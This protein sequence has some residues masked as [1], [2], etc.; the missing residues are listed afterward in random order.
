MEDIKQKFT[1]DISDL[2]AKAKVIEGHYQSF[3]DDEIALQKASQE[4]QKQ[5]ENEKDLIQDLINLRARSSDP[6]KIEEYTKNI[7][8]A[9]KRMR[10]LADATGELTAAEKKAKEEA[11][12]FAKAQEQAAKKTE[13]LGKVGQKVFGVLDRLTFGLAS[14]MKELF[15]S[16]KV[17]T[18]GMNILKA[19]IIST[20]IG[21]L[22]VAVASLAAYMTQTKE[23]A[24]LLDRGMTALKTSFKVLTDRAAD[25]GEK[26][27]NAFTNPK[28]AL[29]DIGDS[30]K[31]FIRDRIE[32]LLKAVDGVGNAFSS[33]MSGNFKDAA[34]QAGQAFID[35]NRSLNPIAIQ[36][37]AIYDFWKGVVDETTAEVGVMDRLKK[38][39][40]ENRDAQRE[41]DILR[42][43]S[44]ADIKALN[45]IAED[46]TKSESERIDAASKAIKLEQDLMSQ[47]LIL[48]QQRLDI[49]NEANKQS[50]NGLEDYEAAAEAEIELNNI[51][52]E[53]LELQTTLN[54]KLNIIRQQ[55][56][57]KRT[58]QEQ[59]Q[60][61]FFRKLVNANQEAE[62]AETETTIEENDKRLQVY[63]D[64]QDKRQE[65]AAETAAK[66]SILQQQ[67]ADQ[68]KQDAE[69]AAAL[70]KQYDQNAQDQAI[71][72]AGQI[73]SI[74]AQHSQDRI[75]QIEKELETAKGA[76]REQLQEELKI[77]KERL[78]K[79]QQAQLASATIAEAVA[80]ARSFSDLGPIGG[81]IAAAGI[82]IKF[83]YLYNQIQAQSFNEGTDEVKPKNSRQ[84]RRIDDIP[85]F[86]NKGE[87]VIQTDMNNKHHDLVKAI[88]RDVVDKFIQ[89]KY[90]YPM[91]DELYKTGGKLSVQASLND[92]N[93]V[94]GQRKLQ[95]ATITGFNNVV[96]ELRSIKKHP[97]DAA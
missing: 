74:Q 52:T 31:G 86:L 28:K 7:E 33:L 95:H 69:E 26:L 43:K 85:A 73:A 63:N 45:L 39:S 48:A 68:A 51:R 92:L 80:V 44:R 56:A 89:E 82:A 20:G 32:L 71:A 67:N 41:L 16:I 24:D 50:K 97:R 19:A 42:S 38:L 94:N 11:D 23:G 4:R 6:K 29:K 27:V 61:D 60:L 47:Q 78:V 59:A 9:E 46:L 81:A 79:F 36:A 21:A 90:I 3:I 22:V 35:L 70:K 14:K 17:V 10:T 96:K 8:K 66:E 12:R 40:Q 76:R 2:D 54:N 1:L 18:Q 93:I 30:I 65:K 49:I 83:A 75:Q 77:E 58:V 34:K 5:I 53:S 64:N 84:G 91:Y 25:L 88:R 62:I 57:A 13:E 37:E 55:A 87:A 72:F 15:T